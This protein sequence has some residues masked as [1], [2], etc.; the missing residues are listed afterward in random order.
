LSDPLISHFEII[1]NQLETGAIK[2]NEKGQVNPEANC[3]GFDYE[4]TDSVCDWISVWG[5]ENVINMSPKS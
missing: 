1:E 3:D 5:Q 4:N 2:D